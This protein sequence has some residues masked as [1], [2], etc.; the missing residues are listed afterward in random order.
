MAD[1]DAIKLLC[2]G[3]IH[4][5]FTFPKSLLCTSPP[6]AQN[7]GKVPI[8][9]TYS[10]SV[11]QAETLVNVVFNSPLHRAA[12]LC[13]LTQSSTQ[14]CACMYTQATAGPIRTIFARLRL[15]LTRPIDQAC[16]SAE[17]MVSCVDHTNLIRSFSQRH[18]MGHREQTV[19]MYR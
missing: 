13:V 1:N 15:S 3:F 16:P 19:D 10:R 7:H 8:F 12:V 6:K 18:K 14:F 4:E 11:K 2:H 17:T 5:D 9:T